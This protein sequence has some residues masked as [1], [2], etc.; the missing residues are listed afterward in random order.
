MTYNLKQISSLINDRLSIISRM[1]KLRF[2]DAKS[3][4]NIELL[5]LMQLHAATNNQ[6]GQQSSS[7]RSQAKMEKL[8]RFFGLVPKNGNGRLSVEPITPDSRNTYNPLPIDDHATAQPT[9][10][11]VYCKLKNHYEGS[12]SQGNRFILNQDL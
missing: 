7:R 10:K 3:V 5:S 4:D 11:T 9:Q 2:L 8:F 6:D 12:Q 1:P